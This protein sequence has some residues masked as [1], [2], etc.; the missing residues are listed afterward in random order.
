ML[1]AKSSKIVLFSL[2]VLL[3]TSLPV[4]AK[5]G[6]M[7]G[8]LE[9]DANQLKS[10]MDAGEPLVVFPLSSIEYKDRHITGSV[11]IPLHKLKAELPKDKNKTMV[12]YC[13]GV[14][15][16]ASWRAAEKA[17][18]LG[19]KNVFAFRK[20]LPAWIAAGYPTISVEKLPKVD[21]A[22]INTDALSGMIANGDDFVL[23]D[24][25]LK[26]DA[27]KFWINSPN[28]V[29]VPLDELEAR[30][31]EVP[32]NKKVVVVCLKGKRS[33]TAIR[34]LTAK[35]YKDLVSVDGGMQQWILEGKP[36][37]TS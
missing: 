5:S 17:V 20:G 29:H 4:A 9:I 11:N 25:C 34:Y 36:V 26:R 1:I 8:Y 24:V 19:Y 18:Q 6:A 2:L 15:C 37:K 28:R 30:L 10:M 23:L 12:F 13:L 32:K 33:P 35:G 22:K 27:D 21:V 7:K 31:S 16:T 14:K 3:L